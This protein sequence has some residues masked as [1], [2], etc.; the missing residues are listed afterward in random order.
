MQQGDLAALL[1]NNFLAIIRTSSLFFVAG[2]ALFN[3]TD[4]GKNF[5]I[6]S[7]LA[8]FL[9]LVS[10]LVDYFIER[11]R[12]AKLGFYPRALID[13]LAFIL[14][15]LL[16]MI[17]WIVF[18]VW[19]TEPTSI[20]DIAREVEHEIQKANKEL[21]ETVKEL[22]EKILLTNQTLISSIQPV[23]V[24]T[25]IAHPADLAKSESSKLS[26]NVAKSALE[27]QTK[28]VY[29]SALAAIVSN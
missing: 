25:A 16:M 29:D 28:T 15:G 18:Q 24:K 27:Q 21:I 5:S 3:F 11:N 23:S 7:L 13:I 4:L 1:E 19:K 10:I 22:N 20:G 8:A 26:K 12:I 6:L 2:I 14:I 9:I 17:L